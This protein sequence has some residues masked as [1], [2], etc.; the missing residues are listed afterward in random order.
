VNRTSKYAFTQ[1]FY[2]QG[3]SLVTQAPSQDFDPLTFLKPFSNMLWV[4]I[5]VE[6][7]LVAAL[8]WICESPAL[9][10]QDSDL[11]DGAFPSLADAFYLSVSTLTCTLD[12]APHSW[13]GK[14][15]MIGHGWFMLVIISSYTANLAS[16]LTLSSSSP[17]ISSWA[18]ITSSAGRYSICIPEGQSQEQFLEFETAR[19]GYTFSTITRPSWEGCMKAVMDKEANATFEDEPVVQ[20]YLRKTLPSAECLLA[21]VGNRFNPMGYGLAFGKDSPDFLLYTQGIIILQEQGEIQKLARSYSIGVNVNA[22]SP[23]ASLETPNPPNS[24]TLNPKS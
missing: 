1:P 4:A 8:F 7:F 21:E 19:Y 2:V 10:A 5:I 16:F 6:V 20:Y 9:G 13:G 23:I 12:K 22:L 3:Y 17:A 18:D 24:Q 14:I 11:S 15:V